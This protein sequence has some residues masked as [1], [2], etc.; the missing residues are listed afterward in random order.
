MAT[1]T[2]QLTKIRDGLQLL[3]FLLQRYLKERKQKEEPIEEGTEPLS[4]PSKNQIKI[5][6]RSIA[7]EEGVDPYLAVKVAKCESNLEPN[8]VCFNRNG[9][10]DRGL[11]QWNDFWHPEISDE[12]AFNVQCST[13]AFCK[14]VKDGNLDWWNASK[15]CWAGS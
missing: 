12:C 7:K 6:I 15:K 10:R 14:A 8:A 9:T 4:E 5:T 3:I 2:E 13:R 11:F 1:L